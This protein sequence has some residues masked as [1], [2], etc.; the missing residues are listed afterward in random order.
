MGGSTPFPGPQHWP[1]VGEGSQERHSQASPLSWPL[2]LHRPWPPAVVFLI[3]ARCG[4]DALGGSGGQ[5]HREGSIPGRLPPHQQCSTGT[6]PAAGRGAGATHAL[7]RSSRPEAP[8]SGAPSRTRSS[9]PPRN[10]EP[11]GQQP[12]HLHLS[13]ITIPRVREGGTFRPG[14][15]TGMGVPRAVPWG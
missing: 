6:V 14:D 3:E 1:L 8:F 7:P 13:S 9:P 5:G 12:L 11:L 15:M 4:P 10:L 2:G